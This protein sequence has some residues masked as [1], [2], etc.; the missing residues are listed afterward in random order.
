MI[1]LF[2]L[3]TLKWIILLSHSP[4]DVL[5]TA[6]T[7][8]N[9]S[10][11]PPGALIT[12]T[13]DKE[14]Y[15]LGENVLIHFQLTNTG[16][17]PFDSNWGGDSRAAP[18]PLRFQVSATNAAGLAMS[19]PYP[20]SIRFGGF[21]H[22]KTLQPGETYTASLELMN[23]L[24]FPEPGVYTIKA[25]HDCGWRAEKYPEGSISIEF[26]SPTAKQ[27]SSVV[28]HMATLP[29][30]PNNS[31]GEPATAF[32][33]FSGLR[34]PVYL[35]PL[36]ALAAKGEP[37]A[38]EG[39]AMV[40]TPAATEALIEHSQSPYPEI[41]EKSQQLLIQRLPYPDE[42]PPRQ[43]TLMTEE[44]LGNYH[45]KI[46]AAWNENLT[47]QL[48]KLATELLSKDSLKE[49]SN[50]ARILT[51]IGT[52][53]DAGLLVDSFAKAR[54][55][56]MTPRTQPNDNILNLPRAITDLEICLGVLIERG[57]DPEK[58]LSSPASLLYFFSQDFASDHALARALDAFGT[59]SW[60]R[61]RIAALNAIPESVPEIYHTHIL[62][63]LE[64]D[65]LGVCRI[66]CQL[67]GSTQDPK[68]IQ[69]LLDIISSEQHKYV[70]VAASNALERL[71]KGSKL[72][73]YQAWSEKLAY[74]HLQEAA[75]SILLDLII[76]P[77]GSPKMRTKHSRAQRSAMR[78][79]WQ[80]WLNEH[81]EFIE[82]GGRFHFTDQAITPDLIGKTRSWSLGDGS[83]WPV[84]SP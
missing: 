73:L 40:Y 64:D 26:K 2:A 18:R 43:H 50:G 23:Y 77:E 41:A 13:T 75:L 10:P 51:S 22:Y 33:N 84:H 46:S 63:M 69:P 25:F 1:R 58:Q 39:I 62:K 20:P 72:R 44:G 6:I 79:A 5:P 15:Y 53:D 29:S 47:P 71:M 78:N 7:S 60:Y 83:T 48:H 55:L 12:L 36:S 30:H 32:S 59:S 9:A 54:S 24:H 34:Y 56:T 3:L 27:A 65:D 52:K 66:A 8:K 21:L 28:N 70:L 16:D 38:I 45:H 74:A 67:A 17:E 19:D 61:M 37:R 42:L 4:A 11:V 14:S 81:A 31:M 82:S 35:Q 49:L 80:N 76:L 57:L 68:F